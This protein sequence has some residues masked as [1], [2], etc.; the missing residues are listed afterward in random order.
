M[1]Y[2]LLKEKVPLG[3]KITDLGLHLEN[4]LLS[5]CCVG[6]KYATNDESASGYKY[7]T[8]DPIGL[9][10]GINTYAYALSN[11]VR[12]T[13][14]TGL[15]IPAFAACV[16]NPACVNLIRAAIGGIIGGLSATVGALSDTCFDGNLAGVA[17][18]GAAIGAASSFVP[19]VGGGSIARA[20]VN[21]GSA[22]FAGNTV[23][24]LV[25]SGGDNFSPSQAIA[26]GL[27]GA[28][29]LGFGN[30]VGLSSAMTAIRTA[31][32]NAAQATA[33]GVSEGGATAALVTAAGDLSLAGISASRSSNCG[34]R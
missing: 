1:G 26:T 4:V 33:I 6:E 25:A 34:C 29:A 30:S 32:A 7:I 9:N 24:Q 27:I 31:G 23:G 8:S 15:I 5:D 21:G 20:A 28:T 18:L 14:P 19:G 11:P 3:Q 13:D 2:A 22:A 12:F 17:A 16:A 10:G